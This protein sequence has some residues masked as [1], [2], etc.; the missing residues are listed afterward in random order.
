MKNLLFIIILLCVAIS[1]YAQDYTYCK[2]MYIYTGSDFFAVDHSETKEQTGNISIRKEHIIIDGKRYKINKQ[3]KENTY[4][5]KGRIVEYI[6]NSNKMTALHVRRQNTDVYYTL[7][8][9]GNNNM[10]T[11]NTQSAVY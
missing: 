8:G 2:V 4:R 9:Q 1:G 10:L 3:L 11:Q 5:A 6:Y 7:N